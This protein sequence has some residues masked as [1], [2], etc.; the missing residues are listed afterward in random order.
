[1][2]SATVPS[3]QTEAF[4]FVSELA[5]EL[6][7]GRIELPA[8]PDVAARV[9][10][11]LEDERV[12]ADRLERVV[13]SEPVLA[14]RIVQLANSVAF[15][16]GGRRISDLR[17]AIGRIGFNM[18]R[19]TSMAYA[20]S[21]LRKSA[22]LQ[23][24]L[25]PLS[26]LWNRSTLVAAMCRVV[27]WRVSSVNADVAMLAGLLHG[28]GELYILTRIGAYPHLSTTDEGR[29]IIRDWRANVSKAILENWEIDPLIASAVSEF[30]NPEREHAGPVDLT[31]VLT[32]AY[33]L[34]SYMG[35]P[36]SLELNMSDV[37]VCRRLGLSVAD[38]N[39]LIE[40]S[41]EQIAALRQALDY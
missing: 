19:T 13:S 38:Y 7:Q 23:G 16:M 8:I 9:R 20:L 25:E 14:S 3:T 21:Q 30:E 24:L 10:R 37:P 31:D 1:M 28:I 33:L 29:A 5:R 40:E 36:E 2:L 34:S 41:A 32:V 22:E 26:A 15:D 6:S 35:Y 27:A 39:A 4:R 11:A 17:S 12:T 18:V